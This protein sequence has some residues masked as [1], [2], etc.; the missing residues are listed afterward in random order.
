MASAPARAAWNGNSGIPPPPL[1]LEADVA[2][3]EEVVMTDVL[4]VEALELVVLAVLEV[5]ELLVVM[6]VGAYWNVATAS[7]CGG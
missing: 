6:T 7:T 2:L 1:E 5:L 4:D 3:L